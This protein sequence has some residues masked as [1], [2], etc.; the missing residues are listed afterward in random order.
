MLQ[1]L[2]VLQSEMPFLLS[3]ATPHP[4]FGSVSSTGITMTGLALS[5]EYRKAHM[6]WTPYLN[7]KHVLRPSQAGV[8]RLCLKRCKDLSDQ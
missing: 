2:L 7:L 8:A 3:M 1:S 6:K 4:L 5:D